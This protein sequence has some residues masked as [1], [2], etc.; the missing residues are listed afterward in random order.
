MPVLTY[1]ADTN[2]VSDYHRKAA[3]VRDWFAA[4]RG[5]VGIST[6]TLAELRRGIELKDGKARQQLEAAWRFVL[7]DYSG[8]IF[9]FDEAAAVEWGKMMAKLKNALPPLGDSLL[10]AIARTTGMVVV[11]RNVKHFPGCRTVNPW[12]A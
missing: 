3:P 11:T 4:H 7:E 9:V 6:F 5:E 8:R 1:L 10:A 2:I 12:A